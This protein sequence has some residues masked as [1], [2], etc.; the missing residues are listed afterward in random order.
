MTAKERLIAGIED[1][2]SMKEMH[3]LYV[4]YVLA[5]TGGNRSRAADRLGVD[6]RTVQR[7]I[8]VSAAR[9]PAR[10]SERHLSVPGIA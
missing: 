8:R 4:E 5:T 6:R 7:W 2:V 9:R 3:L 1:R 10:P